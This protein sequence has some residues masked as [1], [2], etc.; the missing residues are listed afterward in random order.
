VEHAGGEHHFCPGHGPEDPPPPINYWRG[1]LMVNNELAQKG[2]IYELLFR[3]ENPKDPC[4]A[5]NTPP[6]YLASLIN[7]AILAFILFRFG[8][9]PMAEALVARKKAIMADIDLADDLFNKAEERLEDYEDKLENIQTKRKEMLAEYAAQAEV[10]Q[11]HLLT[12]AEERRARMRRDAEFR[13]EQE[14]KALRDALLGEA[15]AAATA[16][17]EEL[18]KKQMSR[19]DQDRMAADYLAS[20]GAALQEGG[21]RAAPGAHS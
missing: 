17:A 12:E 15:V 5:K 1:L 16:A 18:I 14:R 21:V 19:A 8:R 6:P 7:F 11:K 9:K 13:I 2:G 4:D 10:E 20:V 3:Y